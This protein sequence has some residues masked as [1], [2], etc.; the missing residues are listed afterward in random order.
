MAAKKKH[1]NRTI[2]PADPSRDF[3]NHWHAKTADDSNSH[4][5]LNILAIIPGLLDTD[6]WHRDM[7]IHYLC[8]QYPG[9]V[10]RRLRAKSN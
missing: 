8:A 2:A 9:E 5:R 10:K 1:T 4:I 6:K 3:F 7:V